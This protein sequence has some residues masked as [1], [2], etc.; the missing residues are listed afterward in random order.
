MAS[1]L[2]PKVRLMV[3]KAIGRKRLPSNIVLDHVVPKWAGGPDHP[4]NMQFLTKR[5]H[6]IKTAYEN[7]IRMR[8][9]RRG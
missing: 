3:A 1:G 2:N 4:I 9:R 8:L 7:A 5:Q 6:L